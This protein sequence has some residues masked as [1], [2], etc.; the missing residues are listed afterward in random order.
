[1]VASDGG[2][3]FTTTMAPGDEYLVTVEQQPADPGRHCSV[4]DG[5]G[6]VG[7]AGVS[8]IRVQCRSVGRWIYVSTTETVAY[9]S[10]TLWNLHVCAGSG[11]GSVR[12]AGG[13]SD[14]ACRARSRRTGWD[15]C[16][17]APVEVAC[18][19]Q[20]PCRLCDRS[21]D[22]CAGAGAGRSAS[23]A[24]CNPR[25]CRHRS[26]Q[27]IPL[28]RAVRG[29]PGLR[30]CRQ[31]DRDDHG[32]ARRSCRHF[33]GGG[34]LAFDPQGRFLFVANRANRT[35]SAFGI[36]PGSGA[37]IEFSGSPYSLAY[38]PE[39]LDVEPQG[40]YLYVTSSSTRQLVPYV[41]DGFDGSTGAL[42][43]ASAAPFAPT[44]PQEGRYGFDPNSNRIIHIDWCEI[45]WDVCRPAVFVP[46]GLRRL[47]AD[48][49]GAVRS[50]RRRG[51]PQL[52][53]RVHG[54]RLA[55]VRL[56][57]EI[58][59]LPVHD[60]SDGRLPGMQARRRDD[61]R[62]GSEHTLVER[63]QRSYQGHFIRHRQLKLSTGRIADQFRGLARATSAGTR[64][65]SGMARKSGL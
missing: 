29:R 34:K 47:A 37:L 58:C 19:R 9:A 12:T 5:V 48:E 26:L 63:S 46:W 33:G 65:M 43:P 42:R 30:V 27:P 6:T 14:T 13:Q 36:D 10:T 45:D 16:V 25:G 18:S 41:I 11:D 7:P 38:D 3:K 15:L 56:L 35:I 1:M 55:A 4:S 2:F 39:D 40:R 21:V 60:A 50:A 62:V 64:D 59:L 17:C 51:V 57:R 20:S 49:T 61:R 53:E 24:G 8:D 22:G 54:V 23:A 52:P 31:R 44:A 32:R 28:L